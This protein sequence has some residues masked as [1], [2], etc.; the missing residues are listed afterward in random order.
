MS[1]FTAIPDSDCVTYPLPE[2]GDGVFVAALYEPT[3][4]TLDDVD[5]TVP[6]SEIS[7]AD[8][9]KYRKDPAGGSHRKASAGGHDRK[10]GTET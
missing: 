8:P 10:E 2:N 5:G 4:I 9:C 6:A 3:V 7:G 1:G